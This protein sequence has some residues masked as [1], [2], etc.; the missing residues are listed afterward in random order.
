MIR[1][2]SQFV[3]PEYLELFFRSPLGNSLALGFAKAVAQPSLS[4][5]SIRKIPIVVPPLNE[6]KIIVAELERLLSN[7]DETGL[8]AE[9]NLKRAERLQQSI[10]GQAFSGELSL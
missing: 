7:I 4:M 10:L 3:L 2:E 1:V 6:Q 5:G 9:A 8:V